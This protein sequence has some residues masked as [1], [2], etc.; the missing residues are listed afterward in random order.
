MSPS[1][2]VSIVMPLHNDS[3]TVAA[4]LRTALDQT[5]RDI[6]VIC[7]DDASTDATLAVVERIQGDDDRVRI[8]RHSENRSALNARRTGVEAARAPYLLF[9]DGDDELDP[10]A[11]ET[12]RRAIVAADA[13]VLQFGVTVVDA[14]GQVGGSYERR[15]RPRFRRLDG[16]DVLPGLFPADIAAQGQLWRYLFR[17]DLLRA[18]YSHI[19]ESLSLQRVNDLPVMFLVASLAS[20]V[21]SIDDHLYRYHLGRGGSGHRVESLERA[22][23]YASAIDSIGAIGDAVATIAASSPDP[24]LV[25]ETYDGV[26]MWII[27]YVCS[28]LL[29]KGARTI[30][31]D[32][33]ELLRSKV[34]EQ[35]LL[36]AAG[37][38]SPRSLLALMDGAGRQEIGMRDPRHVMLATSTFRTGGVSAVIAAQARIL[39]DAGYT[40]TIVARNGGSDP[41][42]VPA[43]VDFVELP[44][45]DIVARMK[46]WRTI[47]RERSVDTVIDHQVLYTRY[48]PEF[49]IMTRAAGAATVGWLHNFVARPIYDGDDRLAIIEQRATLLAHLVTL[50]PLDVAYL[51]L[52]GI[53]HTSFAPNPP[54]ALLTERA[55]PR[56]SRQRATGPLRLIWWGRLEEKTKRV[57]EL[58]AVGAELRSLGVD[59]RMTLIGPDWDDMT[60]KK[61]NALPRRR[62]LHDAIRAVGPR[63][64]RDLAREIDAADVFVSTSIIEGYQLTIAEAQS[65]GLP[66]FMYELPWLVLVKDNEGLVSAPQGDAARLARALAQVS[67]DPYSYGRMSR[68]SLQAAQR[69]R[70]E[71]F[72]DLYRRIVTGR[73]HPSSSPDPTLQDAQQLLGLLRFYAEHANRPALRAAPHGQ[74][75]L[76]TRLWAT[77]APAGRRAIARFPGLR[78]FVHRLKKRI[79]AD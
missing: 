32:A 71:D 72:A 55:D 14:H 13:Q 70:G 16:S 53:T 21:A 30:R 2:A 6:E 8:L 77:M 75:A 48:W 34:D 74:S 43:G 15:L 56:E 40:V 20:T 3:G 63:H 19:P 36:A 28:Q 18:A 23:F 66:V 31:E 24:S 54:S 68:G 61:F 35:D 69:A 58:I 49:A 17:T 60:A 22:R 42:A 12:A 5:L 27:G 57:T 38:H 4:A 65:F 37:L 51:K 78:P 26:R 47:L 9:L 33:V 67:R 45:G 52:R 29:E 7:V 25:T 76:G 62:G 50:S 39:H 1:P 10:R 59:F 79:G 44:G 64:G 11:A 73:V 41:R 46:A